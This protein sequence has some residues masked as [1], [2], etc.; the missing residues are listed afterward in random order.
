MDCSTNLLL[1]SQPLDLPCLH[2]PLL[3][4]HYLYLLQQLVH[5]LKQLLHL[6][7]H[8]PHLLMLLTLLL[9]LLTLFLLLLIFPLALY[10]TLTSFRGKPKL[11]YQ[12]YTYTYDRQRSSGNVAWRC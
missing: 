10:S 8:L 9:L 4:P 3:L 12:G 1:Y 7:K 6:L 5:L 11:V 2:L